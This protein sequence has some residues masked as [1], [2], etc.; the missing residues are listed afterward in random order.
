[1]IYLSP[2]MIETWLILGFAT[3]LLYSIIL[4][5]RYGAVLPFSEILAVTLMWPASIFGLFVGRAE[6]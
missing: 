5:T 4:V 3:S 6:Q 2:E 1:M